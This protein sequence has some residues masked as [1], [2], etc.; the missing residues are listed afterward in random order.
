ME[1]NLDTVLDYI[2]M[3]PSQNAGLTEKLKDTVLDYIR[4]IPSQ[5]KV[6]FLSPISASFRL[7]KND[8]KPKR[9]WLF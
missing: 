6:S 2:R 5:N 4:M 7:H 8:T 1:Q 9:V 3:I